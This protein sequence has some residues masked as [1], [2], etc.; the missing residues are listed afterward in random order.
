MEQWTRLIP[1]VKLSYAAWEI[2]EVRVYAS[3]RH[4]LY[5]NWLLSG[6]DYSRP[7]LFNTS[8]ES[9]RDK[10]DIMPFHHPWTT[11]S[12]R[13]VLDENREGSAILQLKF[14]EQSFRGIP[15]GLRNEDD[16][17]VLAEVIRRQRRQYFLKKLLSR[18]HVEKPQ[19]WVPEARQFQWY[20]DY[21]HIPE[22]Y[23]AENLRDKA[24]WTMSVKVPLV[25]IRQQP[26]DRSSTGVWSW[27]DHPR[28]C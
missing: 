19:Y 27:R 23:H 26:S 11:Q 28:R 7:S 21:I 1:H 10:T 16:N 8:L 18:G 4:F 20:L 15:V 14:Y 22:E 9:L 12:L 3:V 25:D 5:K 6:S 13:H 24:P 17:V 2:F